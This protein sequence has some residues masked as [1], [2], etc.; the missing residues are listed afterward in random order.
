MKLQFSIHTKNLYDG[1]GKLLKKL[2]C[3]ENKQ[4]NELEAV[5]EHKRHCDQCSRIVTDTSSLTSENL[6]KLL[7]EEQGACL[8][9]NATQDNIH[10]LS[11]A[12]AIMLG[13][14]LCEQ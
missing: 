1:S 2:A 9:I 4:W 6:E 3:P 5:H 14:T 10:L 7:K 11:H 12:E 8:K 13:E